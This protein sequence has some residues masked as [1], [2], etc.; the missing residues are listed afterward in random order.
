MESFYE[1]LKIKKMK[2]FPYES[3]KELFIICIRVLP[4]YT[5]FCVI[6]TLVLSV[7]T[8]YE[9]L[10]YWMYQRIK[11][12]ISTLCCSWTFIY[13]DTLSLLFCLCKLADQEKNDIIFLEQ[14]N[15]QLRN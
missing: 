6:C 9:T 11:K 14:L 8:W 5:Y 13:N 7:A 3:H 15:S 1:T 4:L 12:I 2:I 10:F